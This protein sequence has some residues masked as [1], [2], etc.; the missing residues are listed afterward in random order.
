MNT[1]LFKRELRSSYKLWLIFIAILA[2]YISVIISM[3]DPKLGETLDLFAKAMPEMMSLFGMG[4]TIL[5]M[6]DYCLHS[7]IGILL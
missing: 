6:T 2:M 3:F 5:P 4:Q 7:F 1:T